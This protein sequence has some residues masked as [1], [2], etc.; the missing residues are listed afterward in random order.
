MHP[1]SRFE[2]EYAI[3]AGNLKD[4][5]QVR[6]QIPEHES[7]ARGFD[8]L[9]QPDQLAQRLARHEFDFAEIKHKLLRAEQRL[10]A[11]QFFHHIG[12]EQT[13]GC[14]DNLVVAEVLA[15]NQIR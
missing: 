9:V 5:E 14:F 1:G 10:Q 4:V 13:D 15:R 12:L 11:D 8:R 7:P 6:R 3:K 2:I